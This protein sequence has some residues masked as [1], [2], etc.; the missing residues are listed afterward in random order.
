[1][2]ERGSL[3]RFRSICSGIFVIVRERL[4]R[5]SRRSSLWLWC[6]SLSRTVRPRQRGM[7][8]RISLQETNN[9]SD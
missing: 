8:Q 3:V 4:I 5:L 7:H 2:Y 1:L 9:M 6:D